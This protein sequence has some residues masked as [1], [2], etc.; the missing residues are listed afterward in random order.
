MAQIV[1]IDGKEYQYS[2]NYGALLA[3]ERLTNVNK[4][5]EE[6]VRLRNL[7]V[8]Y[9]CLVNDDNFTMSLAE[10]VQKLDTQAVFDQLNDALSVEYARWSGTQAVN[11]EGDEEEIKAA[12]A[13]KK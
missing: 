4:I 1:N 11:I 13:K 8:H 3:Y 9:C 6:A 5:P 7:T 10:F 12:K 2:Y